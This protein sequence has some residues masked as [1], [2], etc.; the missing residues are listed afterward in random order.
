MYPTQDIDMPGYEHDD[1]DDDDPEHDWYE[2]YCDERLD[3]KREPWLWENNGQNKDD[4][5]IGYVG[6][7]AKKL[8]KNDLRNVYKKLPNLT[9]CTQSLISG[10]FR[11]ILVKDVVADIINI[12][13]LFYGEH[14]SYLYPIYSRFDEMYEDFKEK[15]NIKED[16]KDKINMNLYRKRMIIMIDR[17]HLNCDEKITDHLYLIL[18]H[19]LSMKYEIYNPI[20]RP[21]SSHLINMRKY[22]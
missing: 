2:K 7:I 19:S 17:R 5:W 16:D 18:A 9:V 10:Y 21:N 4:R 14:H 20:A 6:D 13:Q 22:S 3:R 1:D 8:E 12:C 15:Y 11:I